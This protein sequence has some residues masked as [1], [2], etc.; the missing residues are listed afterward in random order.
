[1]NLGRLR[2]PRYDHK[3]HRSSRPIFSIDEETDRFRHLL[4]SGK[5]N[6][7]QTELLLNTIQQDIR[8]G[9]GLAIFDPYGSLSEKVL[10]LIPPRRWKDVVLFDPITCPI[11]FNPLHKVPREQRPYLAAAMLDTFRA[12]FQ[13]E[14]T[15][16]IDMFIRAGASALL[17]FPGGTL[18]SMNYLLTS[19]T[20]RKQVIGHVRD[21]VV[22]N[23]WEVQ[24]EKD[25]SDKEQK[26][27]TLSTLNKLFQ[28]IVDPRI[29]GIIGQSKSRVSLTE[30]M[31][32]NKIFIACLPQSELGILNSSLLGSLLVSSLHMAILKRSDSPVPFHV[33]CD[34]F[35]TFHGFDQL[36]P[37]AGDHN[38][39]LTL[40]YKYIAQLPRE[41]QDATLGIIGTLVSFQANGDDAERLAETFH[42][43]PDELTELEPYTAY[44]TT[45][46]KTTLL[47]MEPP[48]DYPMAPTAIRRHCK[49]QLSVPPEH[50][51]RRI[52]T[53]IKNTSPKEKK[54]RPRHL[55]F[56]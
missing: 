40:S 38:V 6:F 8:K 51:E 47:R 15:P 19:E 13:L 53:F 34:D 24:F 14:Q 20:F 33:Y 17:D 52:A 56:H 37:I 3:R 22:R 31:D 28:I 1:M 46:S 45:G 26:E 27:K 5:K 25:M 42:L 35:Q 30:I 23:F 50:V 43:K 36:L 54:K 48:I 39:S 9:N 21:P 16:L 41:L 29:R 44:V 49:A 18:L 10:Q 55:N 2:F 4:I 7:G 11:S 12:V 32:N